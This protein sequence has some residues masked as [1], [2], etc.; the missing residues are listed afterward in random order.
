MTTETREKMIA[1]AVRLFQRKSYHLTSWRH[2]VQEAGA[3]W[4]SIHHYF[5]GGKTELGRA[6]IEAGSQGVMAQIDHCFDEHADASRAIEC[7]FELGSRLLEKTGYE[8]GCPV[9]TVAL[10]TVC[11]RGPV[12]EATRSALAAWEKRLAAHLRRAGLSRGQAADAAVSVLTLMEGA[13]LLARVEGSIRP[14][15]T[16]ARLAGVVVAE[17]RQSSAIPS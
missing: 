3:P 2:L 6:A 4:G 9:A 15:R 13:L 7:W 1:T 8:A 11:D 5:P 17:T 16:A 14:M 10:E 12:H